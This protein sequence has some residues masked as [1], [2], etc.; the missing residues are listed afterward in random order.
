M[1]GRFLTCL[2]LY[3]ILTPNT[4]AAAL[5]LDSNL[6]EPLLAMGRGRPLSGSCKPMSL[7]VSCQ[8][9]FLLAS[10][11]LSG[12]NSCRP[13]TN[14]LRFLPKKRENVVLLCQGAKQEEIPIVFQ[15]KRFLKKKQE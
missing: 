9:V 2:L 8:P 6:I 12:L 5:L 15:K 1:F 14:A 13:A 10:S 11:F 3:V 7:I 4:R